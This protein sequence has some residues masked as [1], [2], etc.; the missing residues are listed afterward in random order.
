MVRMLQW[1]GFSATVLVLLVLAWPGEAEADFTIDSSSM[2]MDHPRGLV[3][4]VVVTDARTGEL[5][6]RV[7]AEEVRLPD[8]PDA[9]MGLSVFW[10]DPG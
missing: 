10:G 4:L 6:L 3:P 5:R 7:T 2:I 9:A 1:V 8:H